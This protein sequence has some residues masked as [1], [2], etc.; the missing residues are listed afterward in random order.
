MGCV[1]NDI[2]I[3]EIREEILKVKCVKRIEDL[4]V[5]ALGDEK[6]VLTCHVKLHP[7]CAKLEYQIERINETITEI[8]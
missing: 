6:N 5:W 4:H 1:P 7:S 8:I 2:D 3:D